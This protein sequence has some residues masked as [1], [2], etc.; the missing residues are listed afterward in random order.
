MTDNKKVDCGCGCL[1]PAKNDSKT[2]KDEPEKP[3]K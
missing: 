1:P 2:Q 3:K